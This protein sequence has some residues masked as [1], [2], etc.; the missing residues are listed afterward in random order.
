MELQER[1]AL[2][3]ENLVEVLNPELIEQP[4]N[5]G[6]NPRIYWVSLYSHNDHRYLPYLDLNKLTLYSFRELQQPAGRT[7]H[8]CERL[9]IVVVT[10]S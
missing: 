2:I 5:E 8:I 4:I 6:R 9:F 10:E 1:L 7:A 3:N